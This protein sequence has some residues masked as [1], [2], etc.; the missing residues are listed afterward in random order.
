MK[1]LNLPYLKLHFIE[2]HIYLVEFVTEDG[3]N[4]KS[5]QHISATSEDSVFALLW[6]KYYQT[7]ATK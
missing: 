4:P 3:Y 5:W 2:N 6:L 1:I 7:C